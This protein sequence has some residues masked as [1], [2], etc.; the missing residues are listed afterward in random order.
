M[1]LDGT[2]DIFL[3]PWGLAS[4]VGM[5]VGNSYFKIS[6]IFSAFLEI[7]VW[8]DFWGQIAPVTT[9]VNI[10]GPSG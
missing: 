1:E 6:N 8:L 7:E 9:E 5:E 3:Q 10:L 4:V 2:P